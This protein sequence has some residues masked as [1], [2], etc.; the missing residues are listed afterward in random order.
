M[1]G[2]IL[3]LLGIL[4][5]LAAAAGYLNRAL[6]GDIGVSP[7]QVLLAAVLLLLLGFLASSGVSTYA[8]FLLLLTL[9][10]AYMVF[11]S[12]LYGDIAWGYVLLFLLSA[13]L[14]LVLSAQEISGVARAYLYSLNATNTTSQP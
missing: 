4:L 5:F 2:P 12:L 11:N 1:I 14:L 13:A 7:A 9:F 8:S 10:S 6:Y 3:L